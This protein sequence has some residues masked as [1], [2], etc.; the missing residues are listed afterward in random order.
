MR[1]T[2]KN[3][4]F[5]YLALLLAIVLVVAQGAIANKAD[6]KSLSKAYEGEKIL[7]E[8]ILIEAKL[9]ALYDSD[10]EP[11][12][13]SPESVTIPKLLWCL[14]NEGNGKII[15]NAKLNID[16]NTKGHVSFGKRD[17]LPSKKEV[18]GKDQEGYQITQYQWIQENTNFTASG[19][20]VDDKKISLNFSFKYIS[21]EDTYQ[22]KTGNLFEGNFDSEGSVTLEKKEPEIVSMARISETAVF[23]ILCADTP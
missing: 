14:R 4:H 18:T 8:A 21:P 16:A 20:A 23:L 10:E 6:T 9:S 17:Y 19:R 7:V 5:I 12:T 22:E 11:I 1:I 13:D 2:A 15:S 3:H